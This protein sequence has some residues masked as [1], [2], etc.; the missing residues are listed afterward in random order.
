MMRSQ[1]KKFASIAGV[2]LEA[3]GWEK[4]TN[5]RRKGQFVR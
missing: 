4:K 3:A 5:L 2:R 1:G